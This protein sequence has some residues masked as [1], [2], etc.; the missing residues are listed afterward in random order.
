MF[1]SVALCNV[2]G[3]PHQVL[4]QELQLVRLLVNIE[5][6]DPAPRQHRHRK[7]HRKPEL[8]GVPRVVEPTLKKLQV[9]TSRE[10]K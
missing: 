10:I 7:R 6:L 5:E 9:A 1:G 8:D 3:S 2:V 4:H